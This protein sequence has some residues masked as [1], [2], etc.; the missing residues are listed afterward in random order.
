MAIDLNIETLK[1]QQPDLIAQLSLKFGE[2]HLDY[3]LKILLAPTRYSCLV[4]KYANLTQTY[5]ILN[6]ITNL[7]QIPSFNP[8]ICLCKCDDSNIEH[9]FPEPQ[10]DESNLKL[11]YCLDAASL[12]AV[13]ALEIHPDDD[14]LD[15][16]AAPGGKSLAILQHF[17]WD[18][19]NRLGTLQVNEPNDSRRKRLRNVIDGYIPST[20]IHDHIRFTGVDA[21]EYGAFELEMYDKILVDA[22]CS[23]ERHLIQ[24]STNTELKWTV[25]KS[26]ALAKKQTQMLLNALRAVRVG[27]RVVYATC[28]VSD[29]ENDLVVAR[30]LQK[31]KV[32][33]KVVRKKCAFN[34]MPTKYGWLILPFSVNDNESSKMEGIEDIGESLNSRWGPI[35]FA[36]F[37][38]Q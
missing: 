2:D 4:N 28:S 20:F 1:C 25:A 26:K 16:C 6:S 12:I 10:K 17:T 21:S 19:G 11:Y 8:L 29:I 23:S 33:V 14:V 13:E 15:M 9:P 5:E 37:I 18:K 35:Y 36:I 22:P 27:G 34:G 32:N 3:A 24:D 38:R 7:L 30:V 31:T